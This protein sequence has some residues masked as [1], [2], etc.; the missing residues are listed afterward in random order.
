MLFYILCSHFKVL[1][2]HE[3]V[4]QTKGNIDYKHCILSVTL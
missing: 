1:E 2:Q 3:A 4:V